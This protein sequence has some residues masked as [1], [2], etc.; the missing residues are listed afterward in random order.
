MTL[1]CI[2]HCKHA[3]KTLHLTGCAHA[4]YRWMARGVQQPPEVL[5]SVGN[6][7]LCVYMAYSMSESWK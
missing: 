1:F 4:W 5:L 2:P 3:K 6:V 7:L